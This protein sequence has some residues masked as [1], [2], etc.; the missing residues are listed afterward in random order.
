MWPEPCAPCLQGWFYKQDIKR[1][2]EN[3]A[4]INDVEKEVA[5]VYHAVDPTV[6]GEIT[7]VRA[8]AGRA[9]SPVGGRDGLACR[10]R[11]S[12]ENQTVCVRG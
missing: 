10:A 1:R 2:R 3:A 11:P 4:E 7:A 12:W 9:Q 8:G 5:A 6:V